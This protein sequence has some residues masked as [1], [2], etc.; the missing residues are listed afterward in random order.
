MSYEYTVEHRVE[1]YLTDDVDGLTQTILNEDAEDGMHAPGVGIM[2]T[3]LKR[4]GLRETEHVTHPLHIHG[5][6]EPG[7]ESHFCWEQDVMNPLRDN[8]DALLGLETVYGEDK[9]DNA[10]YIT[11]DDVP[12]KPFDKAGGAT[13]VMDYTTNTYSAD[14]KMFRAKLVYGVPWGNPDD[15]HVAV[16]VLGH[17]IPESIDEI[18]LLLQLMMEKDPVQDIDTCLFDD[19]PGEKHTQ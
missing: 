5:S 19:D 10:Q 4:T 2:T 14:D 16:T 1:V 11:F 12:T 9:P 13:I 8:K 3:E 7:H 18:F 6:A 15:Q 17:A